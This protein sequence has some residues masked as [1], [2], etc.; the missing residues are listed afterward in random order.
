MKYLLQIGTEL[1]GYERPDM[2]RIDL[3]TNKPT[4]FK[5]F[6]KLSNK[7]KIIYREVPL[8]DLGGTK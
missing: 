7:L 5:I 3:S 1:Y 6:E 4:E 8:S 2:L